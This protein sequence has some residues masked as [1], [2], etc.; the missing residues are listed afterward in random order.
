VIYQQRNDILDASD[1]SA[2]IASLREGCFADLV[3]Q[4]VPAESVEEQWDFPRWRK[5]LADEWQVPLQLQAGS[6]AA[7]AIT[8]EDILEQVQSRQHAAFDSQG[9]SRSVARTSRSSS[10]WCC[11]KA[12]TPT[13]VST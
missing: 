8:D 13:G 11:C 9:G 4:Y 2:Q 7:S 10:A 6:E 1:L 12:L 3:R 5:V